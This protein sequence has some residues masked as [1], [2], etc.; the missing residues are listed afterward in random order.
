M[1]KQ[2][3]EKITNLQFLI[4]DDFESIRVMLSESLKKLGI[5]KIM[6]A[7]SGNQAFKAIQENISKEKEVQFVIS[8]FNMKD[9]TGL[10]LIKAVRAQDSL[11][12]LPMLLLTSQ[13][14][15]EVVL[16]CIQAGVNDYLIKPW[17]DEDLNKKITDICKSVYK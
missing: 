7:T 13:S 10:D 5:K 16:E 11:K 1:T 14:E 12:K 3:S 15:L 6:I 4:V 8:D 17:K 2:L 9:G